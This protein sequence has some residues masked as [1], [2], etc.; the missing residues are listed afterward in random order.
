MLL[1]YVT[2][3]ANIPPTYEEHVALGVLMPEAT[4][5]P[6]RVVG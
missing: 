4:T 2:V 6:I 3:F 1:Y 5:V